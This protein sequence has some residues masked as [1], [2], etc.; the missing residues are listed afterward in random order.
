MDI[1]R[2]TELFSKKL[3][4][5]ATDDELNELEQYLRTHPDE[6]YF[7]D[8]FSSWWKPANTDSL[9]INSERDVHYNYILSQAETTDEM[10]DSV[11]Q[12]S[13]SFGFNWKK[14]LVAASVIG[15]L[16][17]VGWQLFF[18]D[19]N[20]EKTLARDNEI[21]TKKGT[22]SKVLLPD[23]STVMLNADSRLYYSENFNDSL[24][25]VT[26][27]GEAFFDVV[28][29]AK[30]PF[31]VHTSGINIRVL[32]TAFN[33]KSYPQ[34]PTIEATLVRGLIEVEKTNQ[35]HSSKILLRPNEKLVYNKE[36]KNIAE[37]AKE[38]KQKEDIEKMK[39]SARPQSISISTL[40]R[41]MNDS[42]RVETSW[43]YGRLLFEG[44][45]F[46]ELAP[47]MER[48]FNIKIRFKDE[49]V[50]NYRFRGVFED[51]SIEMAL[52]ALQLTARFSYTLKGS[53][54]IID[55]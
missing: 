53:E 1:Q 4:G 10:T 24:R 15:L 52:Q 41:I 50:A 43:V 2:I 44:D 3:A 49:K 36:E 16:F 27:E 35:P 51:E 12:V 26:L 39:I 21:V 32:G 22:K 37:T 6:Q 33:V 20:E 42:V 23:G 54:V 13:F 18:S 47:K 34:E 48:W 46:R 7:Q 25:E 14:T 5:E 19:R 38:G 11:R 17:L 31:I 55:K 40:P 28:K 9:N 29:D 8:T 45:S 30:R